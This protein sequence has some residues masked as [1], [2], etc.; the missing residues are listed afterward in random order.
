[1]DGRVTDVFTPNSGTSV[2]NIWNRALDKVRVGQAQDV[3]INLQGSGRS[4]FTNFERQLREVVSN[5][6]KTGLSG[7]VHVIDNSGQLVSY[8]VSKNG[9]FRRL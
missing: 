3:A 5:A 7:R 1:M 9:T 8:S 4:N 2:D 6:P